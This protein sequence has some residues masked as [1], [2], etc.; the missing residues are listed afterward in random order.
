[1]IELSPEKP[2]LFKGRHFNHLLRLLLRP[3]H[4][5]MAEKRKCFAAICRLALKCQLRGRKITTLFF[6]A[7][8]DIF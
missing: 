4:G 6:C 5:R 7:S 3:E 8:L 1:M 2:E